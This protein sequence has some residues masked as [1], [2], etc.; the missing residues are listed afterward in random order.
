MLYFYA[1][2]TYKIIDKSMHTCLVLVC[3]FVFKQGS[4]RASCDID[5]M[6]A[7]DRQT[8]RVM[9]AGIRCLV[10]GDVPNACSHA[11]YPQTL[12]SREIVQIQRKSPN[13][14]QPSCSSSNIKFGTEKVRELE[15]G[16]ESKDTEE[17][18]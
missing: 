16:R 5:L 11:T 15:K 1:I 7:H 6:H 10:H 18:P 12:V 3:L 4:F 9:Y 2:Y 14:E 17:E 8:L 13:L